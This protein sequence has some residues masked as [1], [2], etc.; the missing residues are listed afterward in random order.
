MIICFSSGPWITCQTW[1]S[2]FLPYWFRCS[3][4]PDV[5]SAVSIVAAAAAADTTRRI[6][7]PVTADWRFPGSA[8]LHVRNRYW[9]ILYKCA[10]QMPTK[11]NLIPLGLFVVKQSNLSCV[12]PLR[13]SD[14]YANA[15]HYAWNVFMTLSSSEPIFIQSNLLHFFYWRVFFRYWMRLLMRLYSGVVYLIY[16][17]VYNEENCTYWYSFFKFKVLFML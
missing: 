8:S 9:L 14:I 17:V 6:G 1:K 15:W 2:L 11:C 10:N 3:F 16:N 13:K 5:Y 12:Q 7:L 4:W